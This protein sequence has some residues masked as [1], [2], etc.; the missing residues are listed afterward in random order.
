MTTPLPNYEVRFAEFA[1][2]PV[3]ANEEWRTV[4]ANGA[5]V[6]NLGRYRNFRCVVNTPRPARSGYVSVMVAG[7]KRP[8]CIAL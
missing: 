3:L 7:N 8:V 4:D 1:E 6:S 2:P 5:A